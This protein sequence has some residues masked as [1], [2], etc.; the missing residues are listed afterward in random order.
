MGTHAAGYL[1][2]DDGIGKRPLALKLVEKE[3]IDS[4]KA[5][6]EMVSHSHMKPKTLLVSGH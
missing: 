6:C 5:D 1:P 2:G 4:L 3:G